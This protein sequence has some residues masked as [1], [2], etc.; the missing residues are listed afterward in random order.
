MK[1]KHL[2]IMSVLLVSCTTQSTEPSGPVHFTSEKIPYSG[3]AEML[4]D[5]PYEGIME[6]LKKDY[7]NFD[8]LL[9]MET[10]DQEAFLENYGG[11]VTEEDTADLLGKIYSMNDLLGER[12]F[13]PTAPM[14]LSWEG[15]QSC[16]EFIFTQLQNW[17][18]PFT[19]NENPFF[20]T[21]FKRGDEWEDQGNILEISAFTI[22]WDG[23]ESEETNSR[24]KLTCRERFE[25]AG[26]IFDQETTMI[27]YYDDKDRLAEVLTQNAN[28]IDF[29]DGTIF[30][31]IR[32]EYDDDDTPSQEIK[33]GANIIANQMVIPK[34]EYF[35]SE[36]SLTSQ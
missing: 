2:A 26:G 6:A 13:L 1:I 20:S 32:Y 25:D 24:F 12:T 22:P 33:W 8:P 35:Y 15:D 9:V 30:Q 14:N 19:E 36:Q 29:N 21:V 17:P 16:E 3:D 27:L 5:L 11:H 10:G 34:I 4:L 28:E 31:V 18:G 23:A 7:S